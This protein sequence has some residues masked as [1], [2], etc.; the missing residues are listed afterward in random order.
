[1]RKARLEG[2][3]F[4]S[5]YFFPELKWVRGYRKEMQKIPLKLAVPGMKL[6]KSVSNKR[7]MTLCGEGTELTESIIDRLSGMEVKRITVAGHPVDTGVE[8]KSL[9]RQIDELNARFRY[10]EG[11]PLMR[12]LKNIFLGRLKEKAE[13]G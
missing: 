10:V 11:D 4:H 5:I 6:A 9:S 7:G 12:K 1:M 8:E 2:C 3:P 13:E